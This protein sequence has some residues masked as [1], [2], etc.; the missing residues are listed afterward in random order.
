MTLRQGAA[1]LFLGA[2]WGASFLFIRVAAP[3]LG[4]FPLMGGRVTIAASALWL[5]ARVRGT[6]VVLGPYWRRLLLLGLIHAAL[7][8]AL[9]AT[10]EIHLSASMAAVLIAAQPLFAAVIGVCW[11]GE[12]VSR[13]RALGLILGLGGVAILV[14]W[15]PGSLDRSTLWS[16]AASLL[17]ALAY[18]AGGIYARRRLADAPPLTLALGQ[19]LAA[20]VW[21]VPAAAVTLPGA[22]AT[23]VALAAMV[24]LALLSTAVAYV[25]F[26]W[27]L[28]EVGPVRT[29][30]VTYVIPVFG[31]A[32]GV[33][34]LGERPSLAMVVGLGAI[35]SSLVLVHETPMVR[36]APSL[37]RRQAA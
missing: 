3:V 8:F 13:R 22:R 28:A 18:A 6:P 33:L 27:L 15:T 31:V 21:L 1:L 24:T 20:A 2:A 34:F 5:Y 14:G 26:F 16:M 19:Q 12:P 35:M 37:P 32:W 7:P 36:A 9:I 4:P 23:F 25:V 29:F 17:G 30:T 10:A 11:L